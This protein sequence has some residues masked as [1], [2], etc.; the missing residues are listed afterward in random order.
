[1]LF[2]TV[3]DA[4]DTVIKA[5]AANALIRVH[6]RY[7]IEPGIHSM[8][9]L[10]LGSTLNFKVVETFLGE[11][12]ITHPQLGEATVGVII[13]NRNYP[14]PDQVVRAAEATD[15]CQHAVCDAL[16]TDSTQGEKVVQSWIKEV[17]EISVPPEYRGFEILVV[18]Q[19]FEPGT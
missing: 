8:P 19:I 7:A 3:L 9:A 16:L 14:L 13:L 6:R 11:D 4:L 18:C 5:S 10:I 15:I 2:K 1:M 12:P 17:R